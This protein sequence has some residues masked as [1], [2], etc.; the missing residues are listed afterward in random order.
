MTSFTLKLPVLQQSLGC[1][2]Q[3]A[4]FSSLKEAWKNRKI[5]SS[6]KDYQNDPPLRMSCKHHCNSISLAASDNHDNHVLWQSY[7][8]NNRSHHSHQQQILSLKVSLLG[9]IVLVGITTAACISVIFLTLRIASKFSEDF[10]LSLL[11]FGVFC[12]RHWHRS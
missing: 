2:I 1:L 10:L 5:S 3:F 6:T 8:N 12:P 9:I 7:N 4:W 11:A